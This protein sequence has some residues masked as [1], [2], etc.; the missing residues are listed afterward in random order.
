[1]VTINPAAGLW[2]IISGQT[3]WTWKAIKKVEGP[4][5]TIID[6]PVAEGKF[7]NDLASYVSSDK[8]SFSVNRTDILNIIKQTMNDDVEFNQ[9]TSVES[10]I[11]LCA[12]S[13]NAST[14]PNKIIPE[15]CQPF[16]FN[17][18]I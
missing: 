1:L 2:D 18:T 12:L 3:K 8:Q 6:Y 9:I 14:N 15:V 17:I 13:P 16:V 7:S 5:N 4:N 11:T 10:K